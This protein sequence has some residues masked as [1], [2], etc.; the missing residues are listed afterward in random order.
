MG[1]MFQALFQVL[2]MNQWIKQKIYL[3][4]YFFHASEKVEAFPSFGKVASG[5]SMTALQDCLDPLLS[6]SWRLTCH[7]P[8]CRL[9]ETA[10]ITTTT[11]IFMLMSDNEV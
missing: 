2:K 11:G 6:Q 8:F 9:F 3:I 4:S 1:A 7:H 5:R 10:S